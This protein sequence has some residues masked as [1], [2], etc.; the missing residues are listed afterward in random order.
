MA[1]YLC[2]DYEI[3]YNYYEYENKKIIVSIFKIL[4]ELELS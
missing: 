1:V 4:F 2:Y 3:T